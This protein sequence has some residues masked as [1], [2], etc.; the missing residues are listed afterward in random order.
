ML[1]FL[2]KQETKFIGSQ[3]KTFCYEKVKGAL[4]HSMETLYSFFLPIL[5]TCPSHFT[6]MTALSELYEERIFFSSSFYCLV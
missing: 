2:T 1:T 5:V 4:L 6:L 3:P